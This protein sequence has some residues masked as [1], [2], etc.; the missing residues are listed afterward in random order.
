MSAGVGHGGVR[1]RWRAAHLCGFI[2]NA[3][4][5]ITSFMGAAPIGVSTRPIG[6]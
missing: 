5:V 1:G 2:A 4:L 6:A 3:P